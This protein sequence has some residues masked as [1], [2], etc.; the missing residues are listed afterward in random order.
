MEI[1]PFDESVTDVFVYIGEINR[2]GY[3]DISKEIANIP[4]NERKEK[5]LLCLATFG[6]DPDAGYRIGRCL[7]HHYENQVTLMRQ[8]YVKVQAH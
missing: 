2:K 1:F 5:T 8:V 3:A 7:Q 4:L 6:G